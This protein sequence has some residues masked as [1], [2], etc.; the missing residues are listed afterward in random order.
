M[1]ETIE[2]LTEDCSNV[3][4]QNI[5]VI[6]IEDRDD[7]RII[8]GFDHYSPSVRIVNISKPSETV[9][10]FG[11]LL[12]RSKWDPYPYVSKIDEGSSASSSGIKE[13]DCVLEVSKKM[14]MKDLNLKAKKKK[15]NDTGCSDSV[16]NCKVVNKSHA[17]NAFFDLFF[18]CVRES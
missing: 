16:V 6:F 15:K 11:F 2:K 9:G 5:P 13:G 3:K 4:I 17:F 10:G 12:S 14:S 7:E 8:N 1:V 18:A